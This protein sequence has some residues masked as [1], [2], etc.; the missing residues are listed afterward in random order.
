MKRDKVL[1]IDEAIEM[2]NKSV[3][4]IKG[5]ALSRSGRW[6]ITAELEGVVKFGSK[7]RDL[8]FI[9]SGGDFAGFSIEVDE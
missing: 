3:V 7:S 1:S 8:P 4:P 5:K 6:E 2:L 9:T